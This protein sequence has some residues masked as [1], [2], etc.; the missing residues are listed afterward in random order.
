MATMEV[1][2]P[3]MAMQTIQLHSIALTKAVIIP[4]WPMRIVAGG[5]GF[6]DRDDPVANA[7]RRRGAK[8]GEA[9]ASR[10]P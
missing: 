6:S 5:F 7:G 4:A 9:I 2:A 8:N 3:T 10:A 1:I